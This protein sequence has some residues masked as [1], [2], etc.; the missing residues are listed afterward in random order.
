[1]EWFRMNVTGGQLATEVTITFLTLY[2]TI[3][4][5]LASFRVYGTESKWV[6]EISV[7]K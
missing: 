3:D 2:T 6:Y 5:G 4:V 1:M 7:S